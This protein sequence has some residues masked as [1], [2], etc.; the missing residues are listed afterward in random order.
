MELLL[1]FLIQSKVCNSKNRVHNGVIIILVSV[2]LCLEEPQIKLVM[3]IF[4][5]V[6]IRTISEVFPQESRE[7]RT[8]HSAP[9]TLSVSGLN[10]TRHE[11]RSSLSA[12]VSLLEA[13][14]TVKFSTREP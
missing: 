2:Y 10:R 3:T 7:Q 9:N 6:G 4:I 14:S 1:E 8:N 12:D 13:S 5:T 11:H